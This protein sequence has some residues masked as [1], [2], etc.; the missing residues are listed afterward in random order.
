VDLD[1]DGLGDGTAENVG[2]ENT[3]TD[4]NDNNSFVCADTDS[5]GCDDCSAA[6]VFDPANDGC[7]LCGDGVRDASEQCDDGNTQTEECVYGEMSCTVCD[8]FCLT[9]PGATSYCGDLVVDSANG[10]TCDDGNTNDG[11]GCDNQCQPES[12][13]VDQD[14]D[15]YDSCSDCDDSNGL[16]YP[17]AP[18]LCDGLDNNCDSLIDNDISCLPG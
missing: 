9:A 6:G 1:G 13:C 17:G 2:C 16:V 11:D 14:S 12:P 15:G 8:E 4:S 7:G 18:E 3:V 10:E 5:D